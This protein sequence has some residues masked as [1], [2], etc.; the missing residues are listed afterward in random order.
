MTEIYLNTNVMDDTGFRE[1]IVYKVY[2]EMGI[3]TQQYSL[4]N[5]QIGDKKIGLI[6]MIEVINEE[7][8]FN[9]YNSE[10][11]NLY[12]PENDETKDE[13]GAELQ[14]K[15]DKID[16]YKGILENE[17]TDKTDD[18]DKKRLISIIKAIDEAETEEKIEENFMDFDKVIKMVAI[19][20]ALSNVDSFIG[21]TMR[22]YYI[23]EENGKIDIIPFDFNMSLGMM[24]K[25]Y[26]WTEEDVNTIE[27]IEYNEEIHSKIIDIILENEK[28]SEKYS[29]YVQETFKKL[30]EMQIE[31]YIDSVDVRID[32]IV[33]N[34]DNLLFTYEEYK[35]GIQNLKQFLRN[36]IDTNLIK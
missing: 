1:H 24:P 26:F 32:A 14:Y 19:N 2:N 30:D 28:Y 5:L 10:N 23:Y 33:K 31:R 3:E 7:Y 21:R 12:K 13:Y 17:K 22:N 18:E 20:K 27:L 8:V 15:G 29:Q 11:G 35:Q 34:T 16:L 9:R 36:R 6:T 4:G 25:E